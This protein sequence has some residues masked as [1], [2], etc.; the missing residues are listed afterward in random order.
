MKTWSE[1]QCTKNMLITVACALVCQLHCILLTSGANVLWLA[2][3]RISEGEF[4]R[5]WK[6]ARWFVRLLEQLLNLLEF[7]LQF[8]CVKITFAEFLQVELVVLPMDEELSWLARAH[9]FPQ[10][11]QNCT[12]G[13]LLNRIL[14]NTC[15]QIRNS[16]YFLC[17]HCVR[18]F[19]F[20][21]TIYIVWYWC[22]NLCQLS[23]FLRYWC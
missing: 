4:H 7:S 8:C 18:E 3:Q 2:V 15:Q 17:S 23:K 13:C 16:L 11:L 1:S 20:K 19:F 9:V 22:A 21:N 10:F 6:R 12:Q 5:N 14:V